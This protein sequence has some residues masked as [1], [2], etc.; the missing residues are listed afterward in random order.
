ML[1]L[2]T[3]VSLGAAGVWSWVGDGG[4]RQSFGVIL[5]VLGGLLA[6][7]GGNALS[8]ASTS[9]TYAFLG[10]G[11]DQEDPNS[12][13]GLTPVGVFLLVSLPLLVLGLALYG[14]G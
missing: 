7:T 12:G 1:T 11:P 6:L 5:M 3:A 13:E 10:R 14:T 8:R 2:A 9:D 4:L